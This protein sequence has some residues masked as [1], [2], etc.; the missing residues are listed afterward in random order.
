MHDYDWIVIGSG[1]G[2]SVSALRLTE[3][4]YRVG[5][6]EMG[7]R[8]TAKDFP[9][10]SWDAR[11]YLWA[12]LFGLH[13]IFKMTLLPHVFILSGAGVG[14]GSLVY[15]N[16]LLVPPPRAFED[17]KWRDLADWKTV[18][19]PFYALAKRML[20]V[21]EN[22]RTFAADDVIRSYADAIGRGQS[23]QRTNVAI[24]FGEAGKEVPDPF[25]GGEG[26]ARTGCT[27]CGG[28]MIGCKVGAKN[29]LDKNYLFFAEKKGATVIPERRVTR[30]EPLPDGGYRVH[31]ERSTAL[32]RKDPQ[33]FTAKGVVFSAGV[34]GT[35]DLLLKCKEEGALPRL[36]PRLGDFV[37][38]NSEAIL[39]VT[40]NDP[41]KKLNEGIAIGCKVDLDDHTHLEPVLNGTGSDALALITTPLTDGGPGAPRW[42][43]WL[44]TIL[45]S[46]VTALKTFIPFGWAE[47]TVILL[48]MQTLDNHLRVRRGRSWV[49]PFGKSLVTE[50]PDGQPPVPTY[51][52]AANDAARAIAKAIG[53]TPRSSVTEAVL[54][55]PTTAHILGGCAM[56]KDADDGVIDAHC[57]VHGYPGLMVVDGSMIGAN[58]GVNPSLTIT[59]LAEHAMSHVP[60]KGEPGAVG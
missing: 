26:P 1:F 11:R 27:F 29:T 12:P 43:K 14:G 20:G 13:G 33:T 57:R 50:I 55:V 31:T 32:L 8:W 44:G 54:D 17:P 36:S 25:F 39:G 23:F 15:A 60:A 2:G 46:P 7:K 35:V 9:K 40:A 28:C 49:W 38:T 16:T 42:L 58:L 6:L 30:V 3:K 21:T 52:P 59:A 10:T 56:G 51:I 24:Y 5:V 45:A 41:K 34:L 53:G 47:R 4:G 48:V 37:R 18:L 19:P 22:P